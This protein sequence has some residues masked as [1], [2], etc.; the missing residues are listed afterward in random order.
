MVRSG[1]EVEVTDNETGADLTAVT[2]AQI[3]LEEE[4]RRA[5]LSLA[6]AVARAGAIGRQHSCRSDHPEPRGAGRDARGAG[7]R[8]SEMVAEGP[9][10]PALL[11]EV[12]TSSRRR[13]DELQRRVDQG[14]KS[15]LDRLRSAPG[16]GS[17]IERLENGVQSWKR[18]SRGSWRAHNG[19]TPEVTDHAPD[20]GHRS[21]TDDRHGR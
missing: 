15:S 4:R 2:L 20:A 7:R 18:G 1:E 17:E 21:A 11:D 9:G 12:L 8:V 14:L 16:I 5:K 19:A 13:I 10:R 3:I 6:L